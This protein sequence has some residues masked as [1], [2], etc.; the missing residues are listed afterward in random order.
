MSIESIIIVVPDRSGPFVL[1][2]IR[3]V[4]VRVSSDG[5]ATLLV[6]SKNNLN[7]G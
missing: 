3:A 5:F 1:P 4:I 2:I 6:F 7:T